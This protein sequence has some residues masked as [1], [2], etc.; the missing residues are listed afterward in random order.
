MGTSTDAMGLDK[1]R[2]VIGKTYG[3]T[4]RQQVRVFAIFFACVAVALVGGKLLADQL[5]KPPES[6][7]A[8]APWA[9]PDAPQRAVTIPTEPKEAN[10]P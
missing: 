3:P 6:N 8:V 9:V 4:K 2:Q 5:D 1:Y 7:P 10:Q